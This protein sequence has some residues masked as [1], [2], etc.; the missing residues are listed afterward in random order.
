MP[1]SEVFSLEFLQLVNDWQSGPSKDELIK[2]GNKLE[3]L[4]QPLDPKF[5]TETATCYRKIDLSKKYVWRMGELLKLE[6]SYSSWT[7]SL[8]TAKDF[9]EGVPREGWQGVIF[10]ITPNPDSVILNLSSLFMDDEFLESV[11]KNEANINNYNEG[12]GR[13]GNHELEVILK[14]DYLSIHDIYALGGYS[15]DENK[16]AEMYF[17]FKPNREQMRYFRKLMRHSKAKT[18][19]AWIT[20]SAKDR[21]IDVWLKAYE[22]LEPYHY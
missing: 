2:I 17:G 1:N 5:K 18:G 16:L 22:V 9:K 15:S 12:I 19:A 11:E 3:I 14:V 7:R 10:G 13:F 20:D 4:C 8:S 21:S 6:E